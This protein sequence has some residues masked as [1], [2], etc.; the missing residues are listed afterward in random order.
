MAVSFSVLLLSTV[1][2]FVIGM[3]WY[4]PKTVGNIWAEAHDM[5]KTKMSLIK[6]SIAFPTAIMTGIIQN[7]VAL[8]ALEFWR[9]ATA[10]PATFAAELPAV[11]WLWV[12]FTVSPMA[13]HL[14]FTTPRMA[15]ALLIDAFY[16]FF[17]LIALLLIRQLLL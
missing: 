13:S 16:H 10:A 14:A 3:S 1:A 15:T 8:V 7:F 6:P 17:Q 4:N 2:N 11:L 12:G 5:N 9:D